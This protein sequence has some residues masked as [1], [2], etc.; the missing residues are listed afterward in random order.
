M[1]LNLKQI[2]DMQI[3]DEHYSFSIPTLMV[4]LLKH[5][6]GLRHLPL[7]PGMMFGL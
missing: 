5:L 2:L 4:L 1:W 3:M 7:E 6:H